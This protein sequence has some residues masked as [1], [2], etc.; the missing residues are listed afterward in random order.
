VQVAGTVLEQMQGNGL[1]GQD[2]VCFSGKVMNEVNQVC[3]LMDHPFDFWLSLLLGQQV[4]DVVGPVD[5]D[6]FYL[7]DDLAPLS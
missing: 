7:T 5:D 4:A 2:P 6:V 1:W 3:D